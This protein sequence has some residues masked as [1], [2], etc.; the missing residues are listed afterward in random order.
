MAAQS[1]V[2]KAAEGAGEREF[3]KG[4]GDI[5][6]RGCGRPCRTSHSRNLAVG[7]VPAQTAKEAFALIDDHGCNLYD[8]PGDVEGLHWPNDGPSVTWDSPDEEGRPHEAAV[9]FLPV[10]AG[11][12][13]KEPTALLSP[14]RANTAANSTAQINGP[15]TPL[16]RTF[17]W[18]ACPCFISKQ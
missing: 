16:G 6:E 5:G 4:P 11:L 14:S 10:L 7:F 9:G 2:G 12:P 17:R 15:S 8:I 3:A 1:A 18:S 13:G